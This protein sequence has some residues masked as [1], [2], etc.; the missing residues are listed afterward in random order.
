LQ[1]GKITSPFMDYKK[2]QFEGLKRRYWLNKMLKDLRK[3][4]IE[5]QKSLAKSVGIS[6]EKRF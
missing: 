4:E 2:S 6:G 5:N 1:A 3:S